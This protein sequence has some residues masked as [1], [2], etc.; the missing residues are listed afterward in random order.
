MALAGWVTWE[1]MKALRGG[2]AN[3]A[4]ILRHRTTRQMMFWM[5]ILVQSVF[6]IA[7]IFVLQDLV[8]RIID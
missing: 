4:G 1:I 6:V 8:A 2:I 5:T 3:A 7:C